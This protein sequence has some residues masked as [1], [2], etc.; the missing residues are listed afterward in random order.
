[1]D[2]LRTGVTGLDELLQG[3][4]LRTSAVL[5]TGIPGSGKTILGLQ[6]IAAGAREKEPGLFI[7]CEESAESILHYA[8]QM[9]FNFSGYKELVTVFYQ[10]LAGKIVT[11][12]T[13][14]ALIKQKKIKRVVIDS[15]TLFSYMGNDALAFRK[16]VAGFIIRMKENGVT[17]VAT[18]E[19]ETAN[20]QHFAYKQED[21]LFEGLILLTKVRK[22]SSYER[23][24][25]I[26][27]MR[28]SHQ[29]GFYPFIIDAKGI[30]VF[31]KQ[32]PFSLVEH[33]EA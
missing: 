3:G 20:L 7:S 5:V 12:G 16:E 33:D 31:P 17:L 32:I 2:L 1:M 14:I 4:L 6:F 28:Q 27:K 11:F 8:E 23:C 18:T 21:F 19:R 30:A 22:G 25:S 15:L 10:P 24:I 9:G 29:L 26:E 13:I